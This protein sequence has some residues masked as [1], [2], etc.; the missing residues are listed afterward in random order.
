[1][2]VHA[3]DVVADLAAGGVTDPADFAWQAQ[4]RTY[5]EGNM[6]CTLEW[7]GGGG[8]GM[9]NPHPNTPPPAQAPREHPPAPP[10]TQKT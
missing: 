2:D 6:V 10:T 5:W 8:R 1:M 7:G 3:R 9:A 4:L